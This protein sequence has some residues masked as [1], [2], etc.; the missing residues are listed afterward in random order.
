MVLVSIGAGVPPES[1][2]LL[3]IV[4]FPFGIVIPLVRD[5]WTRCPD[6][7]QRRGAAFVVTLPA[8]PIAVLITGVLA[9]PFDEDVGLGLMGSAVGFVICFGFPLV[10]LWLRI[11]QLVLR[12]CDAIAREALERTAPN[13]PEDEP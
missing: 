9:L 5:A 4:V 12:E 13:A 6:R 1:T 8:L 10:F 11:E 3:L 7:R 2:L